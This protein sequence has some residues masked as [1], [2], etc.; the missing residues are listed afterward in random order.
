MESNKYDLFICYDLEDQNWVDGFLL[1]ALNSSNILYHTESAF[2]LGVPKILEFERALHN[3]KYVVL[4][5]SKAFILND[6]SEFIRYLA[7]HSKQAKGRWSVIPLILEPIKL[8]IALEMVHYLD[9]TNP[10]NWEDIISTLCKKIKCEISQESTNILC[11]FPGIISFKEKDKDY[12]YGRDQEIF[13]A[14]T[15]L[16]SFPFLSIIGPSGSGKSSLVYAGIIPHLRNSNLFRLSDLNTLI[17]RPGE[18]ILAELA[19]AIGVNIKKLNS[20]IFDCIKRKLS[21]TNLLIFFDQ[22][23]EIY[24]QKIENI[25]LFYEILL[26]LI[27]N[28]KNKIYIILTV[29]ADFYSDMMKSSLWRYIKNYRIEISPLD[30]NNLYDAI[31]KPVHSVG[32]FIE[33]TLVE[34]L[35]MESVNEPGYLPLIQETLILLWE[36]LERRYLPLRAYEKLISRS[37]LLIKNKVFNNGLQSVIAMRANNILKALSSEEI[38]VS[39]RIFLRLI[40]FGEGRSDIRRQQTIDQLIVCSDNIDLF[41]KT[42]YYLVDNRLITLSG[43][44]NEKKVKVDLAH[45]S[46]IKSW[47]KL[48][49]WIGEYKSLEIARRLLLQNYNIWCNYGKNKSGLLDEY[50]LRQANEWLSDSLSEIIGIDK[51]IIEL[52]SASK[53]SIKKNLDKEIKLVTIAKRAS[54]ATV[55][56]VTIT[57]ASFLVNH[58]KSID[59]EIKEL[60]ESSFFYHSQNKRL[61]ALVVSIKANNKLDNYFIKNLM[62]FNLISKKRYYQVQG[63]L[64]KSI[65]EIEEINRLENKNRIH[66]Q[67]TFTPN[68]ILIFA[69]SD[70]NKIVKWNNQGKKIDSW[71]AHKDVISSLDISKKKDNKYLVS[72]SLDKTIKIWNYDGKLIKTMFHDGAVTKVKYSK[73]NKFIF[74]SSDD[75]TIKVWSNKGLL[76]QTLIGH[77]GT[78]IDMDYSPTENILVSSSL[79]GTIKFWNTKTF[80]V[81]K[82]IKSKNIFNNVSFSSDGKLLI[83]TAKEDIYVS[84]TGEKEK[85]ERPCTKNGHKGNI[86]ELKFYSKN[87]FFT[88]SSDQTLKIWKLKNKNNEFQCHLLK[89]LVGHQN[90]VSSID[91]FSN[92][93]LRIIAS[94]SDDRTIRLWNYDNN[95]FLKILSNNNPVQKLEFAKDNKFLLSYDIKSL[96]VWNIND[97]SPI[98]TKNLSKFFPIDFRTTSTDANIFLVK[99]DTIYSNSF[100][101]YHTVNNF[102]NQLKYLDQHS[103]NISD[104]AASRKGNLLATTSAD[105]IT[106][107]WN[108]NH[109]NEYTGDKYLFNKKIEPNPTIINISPKNNF[110]AFAGQDNSIGYVNINDGSIKKIGSHQEP[111]ISLTFSTNED[112]IA[113][114]SADDTIKL[115]KNKIR[116]KDKIEPI[117]L[118]KHKDDVLDVK[119]SPNG[120][121]FGTASHDNNL[122]LWYINGNY[123]ASLNGR[124]D[125]IIT[126]AFSPYEEKLAAA[127]RDGSIIIWDLNMKTLKKSGCKWLSNYLEYNIS[128]KTNY[129]DL[130]K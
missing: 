35:I 112:L 83:S 104:I 85:W 36:N 126:L 52:I 117:V 129:A 125:S 54:L 101:F 120:H 80:K 103:K 55:T 84:K 81:T 24:S 102:Q 26:E 30:S 66:N 109:T 72:G 46:L 16:K 95:P 92:K 63:I 49:N 69:S 128:A 38:I 22:F 9:A 105:G 111:I 121:I 28:N 4:I 11:P 100:D 50:Q 5:L 93:D 57:V 45:E 86:N 10:E 53:I 15:S 87:I 2:K 56:L 58:Y 14:I 3:S 17:L 68:G 59:L 51:E 78:V 82:S 13:E 73:D 47:P 99:N 25:N 62:L 37:N 23:E 116:G 118:R 90:N 6:E 34:K 20:N 71:L 61:E 8:P 123:I 122:L 7:I 18:N 27:S 12:F 97:K 89:T 108:V 41:Y 48:E 76:L 107:I 60:I 65:Y 119:F 70:N 127:S 21:T 115:W 42:L 79:D 32:V 77:E 88:A 74:S 94:S 19:S 130:C 29:R 33:K 113:S 96:K 64:A 43:E 106:K 39:K 91:F 67:V 114:V 124:G 40:Q 98:I 31:V 44:E 75:K 1:D 110:L